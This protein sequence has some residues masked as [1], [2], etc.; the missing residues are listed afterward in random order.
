MNGRRR[1]MLDAARG[2]TLAG[3]LAG[4]RVGQP[5]LGPGSGHG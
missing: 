5:D 2:V 4:W 1:D 3:W